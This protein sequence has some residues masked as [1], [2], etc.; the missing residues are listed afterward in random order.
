MSTGHFLVTGEFLPRGTYRAR[1]G[2]DHLLIDK[3]GNSS[4][5]MK[6]IAHVDE[7]EKSKH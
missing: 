1:L 7:M 6:E 3:N 2:K 5:R 4:I